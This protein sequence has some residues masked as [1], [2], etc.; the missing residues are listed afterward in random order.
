LPS[1]ASI[2]TKI[3]LYVGNTSRIVTNPNLENFKTQIGKVFRE[4]NELFEVNLSIL[5]YNK[6]NYFQFNTENSSDYDL[7]LKS[8]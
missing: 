8:R 6:T 4:I 1:V 5:N 2:G 3:F 7:E